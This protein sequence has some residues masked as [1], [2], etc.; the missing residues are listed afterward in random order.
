LVVPER[1][2][3]A[4]KIPGH[5]VSSAWGKRFG[6][7]HVPLAISSAPVIRKPNVRDQ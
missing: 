7:D 6:S 2:S 4:V 3:P 1:Q 5:D